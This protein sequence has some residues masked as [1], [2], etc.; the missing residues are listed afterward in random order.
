MSIPEIRFM[1]DKQLVTTWEPEL[2]RNR[3]LGQ[4]PTA[5][6][7]VSELRQKFPEA[8][9]AIERRGEQPQEHGAEPKFRF[10][11]HVREGAMPVVDRDGVDGLS[12]ATIRDQTL[13]SRPF[14]AAE[15]DSIRAQIMK[16][17]PNVE[18]VEVKA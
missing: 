13:F 11:F 9:I 3:T 12:V 7:R 10:M 2:V 6:Q 16:Q 1:V 5:V 17:F 18:L 8:A 14:T 4:I 15:R